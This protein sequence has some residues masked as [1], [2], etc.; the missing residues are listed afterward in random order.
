MIHFVLLVEISERSK[1]WFLKNFK[2]HKE[3]LIL[4]IFVLYLNVLV[5]IGLVE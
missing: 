2:F 4:D 3:F 5:I 1:A